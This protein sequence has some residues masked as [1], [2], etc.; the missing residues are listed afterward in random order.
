MLPIDPDRDC[1]DLPTLLAKVT[2]ENIGDGLFTF[3]VIEIVEGGEST[4]SGAVRVIARAR[5]DVE[6]VLEALRA[7]DAGQK[8]LASKI[9]DG[10]HIFY[11]DINDAFLNEKGQLTQEIMPDLLHPNKEGYRI[12][13]EAMEPTIQELMGK[14]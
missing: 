7:A 9:A 5:E 12:W 13:A 11:M 4:V 1:R 3:M 14:K 10:K 8:Q 6:A 2:G